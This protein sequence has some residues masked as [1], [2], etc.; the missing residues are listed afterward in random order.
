M[1]LALHGTYRLAAISAPML[2][3]FVASKFIGK[4]TRNAFI[5]DRGLAPN[6][7]TLTAPS[8]RFPTFRQ[9][10]L[11]LEEPLLLDHLGTN[12]MEGAWLH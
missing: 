1:E 9:V 4:L 7:A 3:M 12:T 5:G 11:F 2:A 10:R 8:R 6:R